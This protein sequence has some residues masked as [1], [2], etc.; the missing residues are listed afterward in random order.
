MYENG[1]WFWFLI[2]TLML[3]PSH[4]EIQERVFSSGFCEEYIIS[5]V[6]GFLDTQTLGLCTGSVDF[7]RDLYPLT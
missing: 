1:Y 3:S 2:E 6:C 7:V 4:F 5:F